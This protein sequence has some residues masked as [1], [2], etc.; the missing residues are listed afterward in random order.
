MRPTMSPAMNTARIAKMSRPLMPTPTPPGVTSPSF[1]SA[2]R[3]S[4]PAGVKLSCIALTEP[5][6]VAVV[7]AAH[8]AEALGPN[9][10]SLPSM[11]PPG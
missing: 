4:P 2:S 5:F 10:D 8:S 3:R 7:E 11:F 6:D 9:R 1:M